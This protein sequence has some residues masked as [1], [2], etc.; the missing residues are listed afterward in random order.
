MGRWTPKQRLLALAFVVA[1]VT[2]LCVSTAGAA[3][4]TKNGIR[5][6]SPKNG[7]TVPTVVASG[8][9]PTFRA[10]V[11]GHGHVWFTVCR[12][13]KRAADGQLCRGNADALDTGKK[14]K[15]TKKGRYYSFK[16]DVYTF[17]SYYLNTPGTYYWQ[18]FRISCVDRHGRLDCP[19]E[20]R[21]GKFV[22]K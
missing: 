9:V 10:R 7:A 2:A 21:L 1:A 18:V 6:L 19:Q 4:S 14:G 12:S 17:P 11:R 13:K 22:V 3:S 5:L 16:P 8:K 15:K 20:S